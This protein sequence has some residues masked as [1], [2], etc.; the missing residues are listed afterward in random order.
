MQPSKWN[1]ANSELIPK[2]EIV[3]WGATSFVGQLVAAYLWPRYG[4]TGEISFALGGRSKSKL[5]SLHRD[6]EADDRLPLIVGNASD[7]TFLDALTKN[8]K[9]V[10]STVGPYAKYGSSLV[11]ACAANGTDYCDLA[12]ETQWMYRMID[13]HQKDAEAS[14]A[15]IVHACGFD[16]IPS[17]VTTRRSI[18]SPDIAS[19]REAER[20]ALTASSI[21]ASL[22]RFSL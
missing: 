21:A 18:P 5:E 12:G 4:T 9:V 16:S 6:L 11:A 20:I 10:V 2:A 13:S 17:D 14:G 22:V 19:R 1:P 3:L 7:V 8:A 15:R